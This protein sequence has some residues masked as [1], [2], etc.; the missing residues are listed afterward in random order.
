M[1]GH[2]EELV[3]VIDKS[4]SMSGLEADTVGGYNSVLE[5]NRA[6]EG[7]AWVTCVLFDTGFEV[8]HDRVPIETVAPLKRADY[9]PGGCT[10]L[11]DAV[12]RT[13]ERVE[14]VRS[15]LPDGYRPDHTTFAIITDGEENASRSLTYPMVKE[16]IEGKEREG[17]EFLFLGAN[18]DVASHAASMGIRPAMATSYSADETG[19]WAAFDSFAGA[20]AQARSCGAV[21]GSWSAPTKADERRRHGGHGSGKGHGGS[22]GGRGLF[23][24]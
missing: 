23:R 16:M 19:T 9:V 4:G 14:L 10:A 22:K 2:N 1:K 12:G 18:I 5:R 11:L 20:V 21:D 17:W 15:H 8:V 7:S 6:G 3:F 13:I 24:R